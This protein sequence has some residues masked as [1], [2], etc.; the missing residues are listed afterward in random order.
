MIQSK[1][2][3]GAKL[4][5]RI[6]VVDDE[7]L[8]RKLNAEIFTDVGYAVDV[9]EDGANAWD[10]LQLHD[11]HLLVTDNQMPKMSGVELVVKVRQAGKKL[12]VVMVT[13]TLPEIEFIQQKWIK[14]FAMLL[15]PYSM[16]ELL[17][18]AKAILTPGPGGDESMEL[19]PNWEC[20]PQTFGMRLR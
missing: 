12:P 14:P 2:S 17:G 6:L 7:P 5:Q 20:Q 19:A 1:F 15:K 18:V 4:G 9:A 8:L 16:A 11:Y 10:A 3:P 13:G